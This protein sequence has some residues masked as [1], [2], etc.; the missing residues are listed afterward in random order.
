MA[1]GLEIATDRLRLCRASLRRGRIR[2]DRMLEMPLASGLVRPSVK[3]TGLADGPALTAVL[4]ELGQQAG[5]RGWVRV[6]LPDPLFILRVIATD[7]VPED[8][9]E[10]RRFLCWQARDLIPFPADQARL[11]YQILGPGPDGR[12]RTSCLVVRDRLLREYEQALRNAG[13]QA[14]VLDARSVAFAQAAL[15]GIA[16]RTVGLL[17]ADGERATLLLVRDGRPQLWRILAVDGESAG[18]GTRLVREVA[19]S[20]AFFRE[21][22]GLQTV[23]HLFVQG[24][25]NHTAS[26]ASGLAEWLD[27]ATSVLDLTDA[28]ASAVQP[29]D[30]AGDPSHWGAALGAA[31][32]PW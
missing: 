19:D 3:E 10:A 28:V 20:L 32:R 11:D 29:N 12:L 1:W 30:P 2:I 15:A 8:R 17:T 9:E 23:D 18:N 25:G 31:I 4:N 26:I 13:L 24:L 7:A 5:C 16:A 22:E 14:G 21:A 6:A 27:I